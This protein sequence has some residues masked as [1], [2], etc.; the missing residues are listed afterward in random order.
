MTRFLL[1]KTVFDQLFPKHR[2]KLVFSK[3][4]G[5][6]YSAEFFIINKSVSTMLVIHI[7]D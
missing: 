5:N 1:T 3:C 7:Y 6:W 2:S 4:L